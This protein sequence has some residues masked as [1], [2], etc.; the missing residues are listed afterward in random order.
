MSE[1]LK[2]KFRVTIEKEIEVDLPA[3]FA[4]E[5]Y[6]K[7]FR[8]GLWCVEG[9]DDVAEY[10]A[11]MAA[12]CGSGYNHDGLGLLSDSDFPR[13]PDVR[14]RELE[15]DMEAEILERPI[16]STQDATP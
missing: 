11:R 13:P 4:S 3:N 5:E 7:D 14:F 15:S 8:A 9:G 10:A 16:V 6:L 2:Y 1:V 12:D